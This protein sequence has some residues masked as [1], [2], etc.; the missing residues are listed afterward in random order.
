MQQHIYWG[1]GSILGPFLFLIC[2]NNFLSNIREVTSYLYTDDTILISKGS[3]DDSLKK[4][5]DVKEATISR[6][7]GKLYHTVNVLQLLAH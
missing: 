7:S 2:A 6:Y 1:T 3:N 4:M 5:N